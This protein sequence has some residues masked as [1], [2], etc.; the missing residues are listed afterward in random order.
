MPMRIL[1]KQTATVGWRFF[2]TSNKGGVG[3]DLK[4]DFDGS[5]MTLV[6]YL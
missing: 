3:L 1:P 2:A 6:P 4:G 5:I